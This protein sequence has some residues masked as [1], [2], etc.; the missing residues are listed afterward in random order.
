MHAGLLTE[1]GSYLA[2]MR[3]RFAA[4]RAWPVVVHLLA[5]VAIHEELVVELDRKHSGV[6]QLA[7]EARV[8]DEEALGLLDRVLA[9]GVVTADELP[10][11]A[12]LRAHIAASA[13]ADQHIM[14]AMG[15]SV[16]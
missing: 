15:G 16:A 6:S 13:R 3:A 9:D 7:H 4:S 1:M 2:R 14:E 5:L 12:Q 10:L 8:A 11:M